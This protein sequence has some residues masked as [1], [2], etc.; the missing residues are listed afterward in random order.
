VN[1]ADAAKDLETEKDKEKKKELSPLV[2]KMKKILKDDVKDVIVSS[3]LSDSPSCV[4][5][6]EK[7][8]TIQFQHLMKAM[9]QKSM[10]DV[11]PI[12]EIN[13]EHEIIKK[14]AD[15]KDDAV[16]EDISRLL[17]EQAIL[18]EGVELK[19]VGE[20]V[21]RLNRVMGKSI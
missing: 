18:I 16:I 14:L 2:K 8:P 1:R 9:G 13:P 19:N 7:D 12:L 17:L 6:D 15:L 11:K 5:A 3:R 21:K 10:Q 20:F 4:V